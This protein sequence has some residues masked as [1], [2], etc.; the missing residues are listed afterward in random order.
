MT[1]NN[2]HTALIIEDDPDASDI[3]AEIVKDR[4]FKP[5]QSA[6]G[7]EGLSKAR[8]LDPDIV[9]LDIMLPDLD[10]YK[11]CEA[12]KLDRETN[13]IPVIMVTALATNEHRVRGFRVGADAYVTKPYTGEE[14][15]EA[16]DQAIAVRKQRSKDRSEV[17]VRFDLSSEVNNLQSVNELLNML[18]HHSKM[19]SKEI[20][21]L[22]TALLEIGSNAIEWGNKRDE[23]KVVKIAAHVLADRVEIDVEDEGEGFNPTN[24]PH[25][26]SEGDDDPTRHF[27]VRTMLGMREG[28]FGLMITRGLVDEVKYNDRGNKVTLIKRIGGK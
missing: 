5:I 9:F 22:R 10:G 21:Q 4:H 8:E 25:A 18:F 24:L 16:M 27:A 14:I 15:T 19:S 28:G 17:Y 1:S 20:G 11:V 26:A 3:L 12:L 6:S 7:E 13:P 23:N 2:G